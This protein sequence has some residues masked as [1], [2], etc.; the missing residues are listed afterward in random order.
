[1]ASIVYILCALTSLTCAVLLYRG[2]RANRFRLLFWS[3][4]GFAGF[5]LNNIFLFL[6]Q[7]VIHNHDLSVFRTIPGAIGMI[8][9][10]YGLITEET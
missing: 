3:S 5:A 7:E 8:I 10:V 4:I 6:D 9:M 2:Y 1:M